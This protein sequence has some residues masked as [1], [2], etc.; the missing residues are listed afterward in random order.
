[1]GL[2]HPVFCFSQGLII[3][4]QCGTEDDDGDAFKT[5]YPFP[6]FA[7]LAAHLGKIYPRDDK[8]LASGN[9]MGSAYEYGG[10]VNLASTIPVLG[11]LHHRIS[12]LVGT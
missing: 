3:V 7:P 9:S 11:C 1:M 6:T 5:V 8:Q 10:T 2:T 4:T 12:I